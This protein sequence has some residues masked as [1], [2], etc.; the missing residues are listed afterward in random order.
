MDEVVERLQ[1]W[2]ERALSLRVPVIKRAP[3]S[4]EVA[5]VFGRYGAGDLYSGNSIDD[6][7]HLANVRRPDTGLPLHV[8]F[9]MT[10]H[11]ESGICDR[12]EATVDGA[13]DAERAA[14]TDVFHPRHHRG[15]LNDNITPH[16]TFDGERGTF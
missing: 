9:N 8:S 1:A 7:I 16:I 13:L 12:W 6:N 10:V 11:Q 4:G 14:L 5:I 2:L 3:E 15:H